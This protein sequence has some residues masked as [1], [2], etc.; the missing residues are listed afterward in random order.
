MTDALEAGHVTPLLERH[1]AL[2][3]K[4]VE[5]GGWLMALQYS[6]ILAEHRKLFPQGGNMKG[7][8]I[9]KNLIQAR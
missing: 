8:F 4:L 2:G 1:Q 9:Q 5:F 7:G 6:G 3:A